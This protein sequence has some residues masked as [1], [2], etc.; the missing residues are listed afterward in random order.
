MTL[1]LHWVAAF[2]VVIAILMVG[3]GIQEWLEWRKYK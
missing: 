2:L 3:T 1:L